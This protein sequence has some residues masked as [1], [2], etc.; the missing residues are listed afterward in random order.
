MMINLCF[1]DEKLMNH[2]TKILR[3]VK[4]HLMQFMQ[5]W[6]TA[7]SGTIIYCYDFNM[8]K[9]IHVDGTHG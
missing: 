2:C 8:E 9:R 6:I 7:G 5:L 1:I 4:D 3:S